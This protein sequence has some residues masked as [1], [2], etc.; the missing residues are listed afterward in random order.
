MII[1]AELQG[2]MN[3]LVDN[4]QNKNR[5]RTNQGYLIKQALFNNL[6]TF[7]SLWKRRDITTHHLHTDCV[8]IIYNCISG[9]KL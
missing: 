6:E 9:S 8:R 5:S 1:T 4:K 7:V 3:F 2:N